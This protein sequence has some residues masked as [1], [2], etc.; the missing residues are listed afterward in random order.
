MFE[1]EFDFREAEHE[2]YPGQLGQYLL[3]LFCHNG[4]GLVVLEDGNTSVDR[5]LRSE[6]AI[7]NNFKVV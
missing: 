3:F 2:R 1:W 6:D 7:A 4:Y 5:L